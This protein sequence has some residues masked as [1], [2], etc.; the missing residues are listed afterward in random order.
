MLLAL[1]SDVVSQLGFDN[2]ADIAFAVQMAMDAA[3]PYLASQL[4]T[5]FGAGS[6]SDMFY[7]REPRYRDG[8]GY[9]TELRLH[10]GNI[11]AI[12]SVLVSSD[13]AGFANGDSAVT[14]VTANVFVDNDKGIVKDFTTPYAR[15][16][17]K[18]SY[19]AGFATDP[20]NPASYL[21]SSI[22]DWLQNAC[23]L[24]TLIGLVDSPALSEAQIKLDAKL[25]QSQLNALLSRKIRYAPIA[26]LPL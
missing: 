13:V 24:K 17:I 6:Y 14:D 4:N 19:T 9:S 7:I 5:D 3:E 18:I 11:T 10:Q 21:I 23:K 1:P 26:A 8:S 12:T 15:Q 16:F 2:M 25:L 22:P 20:A